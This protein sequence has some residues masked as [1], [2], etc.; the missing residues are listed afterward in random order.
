MPEFSTI[1]EKG[2]VTIPSSIRKEWD[3]EP[4]QKVAFVRRKNKTVEVKPAVDFFVLRGSIKSDKRYSDK[5]AN[6]AIDK[7]FIEKYARKSKGH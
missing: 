7:Y 3:I 2:Q 5:K 6:K 4:G 1:T